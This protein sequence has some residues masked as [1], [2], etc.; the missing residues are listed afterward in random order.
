MLSGYSHVAVIGQSGD[1]GA[2]ILAL[3]N[4]KRWLVQVKRWTSPIGAEVIE[5]TIAAVRTYEADIPVIVSRSG[6]TTGLIDQ[7]VRLASEGM[8]VQLWDRPALDRLKTLFP[9]EAPATVRPGEFVLRKYQSDACDRILISWLG[10]DSRSALIVLAT[11][12]GKTFVAGESVRRMSNNKPGLRVLVLA[13][14]NDLVYQL[15]RAFWPFLR[16]DQATVIVNGVEKPDWPDIEKF[17]VVFSTR[18]TM[19]NAVSGGIELGHFDLVIVDECHHLGS[20]TYDELLERL[21]TTEPDGPFLIG[22]TATPWRPGGDELVRWFDGPTVSIDLVKGLKTGYLA[23]V[24]YRMYTDNVDWEKLKELKGDRF[25]PRAINRTLFINEWDDAVVERTAEAWS[26]LESGR[27]IV[28]CG[29]VSH[30]DRMVE[31]INAL[32][33][34]NAA[35]IYSR[36]ISGKIM[37]PIDRNRRLWDFADGKVGILC[38]VD[39]LNE[40]VDV[41]DVNLVVFQRVT[42]SRRIFVQQLGR[43]L[44]LAPHKKTV[45]VLDFVSD[46]RR[47]AAGLELQKSLEEGGPRPGNEVRVTL[48]SKVTFNRA[49]QEDG[50][51]AT[52]LREWLGDLEEVEEAGEDVSV[53]RYPP[54]SFPGKLT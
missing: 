33:F 39:V 45:V 29:T 36:G 18:D 31:R 26:T 19:S 28:F 12:L 34:T 27:G 11:G 43:G 23:N 2:D 15:E 25:T 52:F 5:R 4:G 17:D 10:G 50:V 35:A 51:G 32:G 41:P 7:R 9:K 40:G 22:L 6:F 38:A 53:L 21:G 37:G 42:H 49:N 16:G 8:N 47:F 46:V 48:P 54:Q 3:K 20:H 1:G 14:T 30:A 24:D 13:H 44:R